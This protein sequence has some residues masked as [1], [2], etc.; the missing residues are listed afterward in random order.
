MISIAYLIKQPIM[1]IIKFWGLAII[2]LLATACD[3]NDDYLETSFQAFYK[4]GGISISNACIQLEGCTT[5]P[6][7]DAESRAF[8][9]AADTS[10]T[11]KMRR[12]NRAHPERGTVGAIDWRITSIQVTVLENLD[13]SHPAGS[14]INDLVGFEYGYKNKWY[15]IPLSEIKYGAIMLIDYYPHDPDWWKPYLRFLSDLSPMPHIEV[16][17]EDAFGRTLTAQNTIVEQ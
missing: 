9:Q 15:S 2:I 5:N 6:E 8:Y 4:L 12:P 7:F 17:I 14:S 1:N 11:F 10:L 13:D 3:H 16:R